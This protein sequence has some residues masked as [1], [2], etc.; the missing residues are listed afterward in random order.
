MHKFP[1][2]VTPVYV[3]RLADIRLLHAEALANS[4]DPAAPPTSWTRSAAAPALA[5]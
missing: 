5:S 3:M 4:G 1:T 2:N